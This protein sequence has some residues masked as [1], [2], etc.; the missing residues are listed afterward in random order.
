MV[1]EIDFLIYQLIFLISALIASPF[2]VAASYQRNPANKSKGKL[3]TLADF[4]E[5]AKQK[6][7]AGILIDIRV[8][9]LIIIVDLI[10]RSQNL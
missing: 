9:F 7:F 5:F 10:L 3:V 2:S 8:S 4:L 6:K 1:L